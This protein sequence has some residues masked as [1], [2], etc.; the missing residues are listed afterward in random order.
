MG[1]TAHFTA[2]GGVT[3]TLVNI[4]DEVTGAIYTIVTHGAGAKTAT[5]P[6]QLGPAT[7]NGTLT[8]SLNPG[9]VY[10]VQLVGADYPA[11]ESSPQITA[12]QTPVITGSNGQ[13][14][15]TLTANIFQYGGSG[16]AFQKGFKGRHHLIHAR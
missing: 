11:Y 8:A 14:D 13:A 4:Q 1:G 5:L 10:E 2:P 15:I 12:S 3:E 16:G 6:D 9:D 7:G